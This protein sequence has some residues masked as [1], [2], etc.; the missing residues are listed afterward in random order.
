MI[1]KFNKCKKTIPANGDVT[2]MEQQK[3]EKS[4]NTVQ[5]IA[6]MSFAAT[7]LSLFDFFAR[8]MVFHHSVAPSVVW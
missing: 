6:R 5:H 2:Y 4:D 7:V 3:A 1:I 8:W